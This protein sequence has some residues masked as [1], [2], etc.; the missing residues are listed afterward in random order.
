MKNLTNAK[1]RHWLIKKDK[2]SGDIKMYIK[3]KKEIIME[4]ALP[5]DFLITLNDAGYIEYVGAKSNDQ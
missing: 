4:F 1:D 2:A 3:Y 5:E